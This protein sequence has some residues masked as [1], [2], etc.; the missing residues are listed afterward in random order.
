MRNEK[1]KGTT[2]NKRH[3]NYH[4]HYHYRSYSPYPSPSHPTCA[5]HAVVSRSVALL[6]SF[7]ISSIMNLVR[8]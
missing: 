5:V 6:K 4:Y 1:K 2:T 7:R 8:P 3:C